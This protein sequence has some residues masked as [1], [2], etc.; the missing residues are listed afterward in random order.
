[1]SWIF[2]NNVIQAVKETTFRSHLCQSCPRDFLRRQ[3]LRRHIQSA[4][5]IG[6]VLVC[7]VCK[8]NFSRSDALHRHK[9]ANRCKV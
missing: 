4:H 6:K 7:D 2:E 8:S 1:M 3:D 9:L 5:G